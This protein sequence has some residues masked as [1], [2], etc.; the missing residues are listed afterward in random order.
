LIR[1]NIAS[2]TAFVVRYNPYRN[3][4]KTHMSATIG[5]GM[6]AQIHYELRDGRGNLLESTEETDPHGL[7][8]GFG[9]V[10]PGLEMALEG[11]RVG[12]VIHVTVPPE[13]G[14]GLREDSEI[15]EVERD[16]FPE[17]ADIVIGQEFTAEG[18]DGTTLTM[19]VLKVHDDHVLVDA[20]HPL[21][22]ETLNFQV[23]VLSVRSATEDEI[24]A[25]RAEVAE[26]TPP[27]G[28]VS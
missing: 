2:P 4:R 28:E 15:F 10:V 14:Y 1:E 18:D 5:P 3:F 26:R 17:G 22:G 24:I 25:A 20:N 27:Q 21:A 13:D 6:F 19:R 7:I 9:S 16:E 8:W 12:E 11:A 23:R